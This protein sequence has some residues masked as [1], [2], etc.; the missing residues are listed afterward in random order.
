MKCS[1][2]GLVESLSVASILFL[3]TRNLGDGLRLFLAGI[4]LEKV[5]DISLPVAIIILGVATIAYI[6]W[7]PTSGDLE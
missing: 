5:L 2:K 4:A 6:F 7:W 3:I 1:N